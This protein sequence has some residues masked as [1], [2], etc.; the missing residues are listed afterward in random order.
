[1][2]WT[3]TKYTIQLKCKIDLE[4]YNKQSYTLPP[5]E[6]GICKQWRFET[7]NENES[8]FWALWDHRQI[9]R[10]INMDDISEK[11]SEFVIQD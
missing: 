3:V 9:N 2:T 8:L 10:N 4:K 7:I 6:L 1:M 5:K 11:I